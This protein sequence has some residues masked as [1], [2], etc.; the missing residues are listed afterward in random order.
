M[1]YLAGPY[2][3]PDPVV[4]TNAVCRVATL[5][6]ETTNWVPF[7]PHITLMWHAI[8]P[9]PIDFWYELDIHHMLRCDA[10]VRLPGDSSGADNEL[11]EAQLARMLVVDFDDLPEPARDVWLQS[12]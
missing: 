6:F 4:N 1:L 9:R 3:R 5:L 11:R 7:V 10:I 12:R 8:T 2:T